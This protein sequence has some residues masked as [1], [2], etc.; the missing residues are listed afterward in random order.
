MK[1][2]FTL[3][4]ALWLMA[5]FA[6]CGNSNEVSVDDVSVGTVTIVANGRVYIPF[7]NFLDGRIKDGR[8][9]IYFDG[10]S[11]SPKSI[12][13]ELEPILF[14]ED[15]E[16]IIDGD[17]EKSVSYALYDD[18]FEDDG[19]DRGQYESAFVLPSEPGEYILG[20][21]VNWKNGKNHMAYAYYA[22]IVF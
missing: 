9:E 8:E 16:I 6:G 7:I 10:R 22:R 12:V 5:A 13:D 14:G 17:S 1:K 4:A 11:I 21:L 3:F 20:I 18:I 15:F 2:A 19:F